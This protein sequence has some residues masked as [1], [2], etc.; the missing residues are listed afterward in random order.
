MPEIEAQYKNVCKCKIQQHF[1]KQNDV[2]LTFRY[3]L[4]SKHA[5]FLQFVSFPLLA[6]FPGF[7]LI[8]FEEPGEPSN[9]T[10]L[11]PHQS[12]THILDA[13]LAVG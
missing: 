6:T 11:S 12:T 7:L 10:R 3:A 9:K 1:L 13:I 8:V 5:A 4:Y 2:T